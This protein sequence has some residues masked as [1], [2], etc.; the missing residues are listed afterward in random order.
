[1]DLYFDLADPET[2]SD[3]EVLLSLNV[4]KTYY[5]YGDPTPVADT[6]STISIPHSTAGIFRG[7]LNDWPLIPKCFRSISADEPDKPIVRSYQW[8]RATHKFSSF[9]ERAE[10]QNPA[11]PARISDRMQIAQHFGVPTPLLDWSQN[12]FA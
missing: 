5:R 11:F 10:V 8:R 6:A 4:E 2:I 7:Q 3:L 12:I 1:M 9:C